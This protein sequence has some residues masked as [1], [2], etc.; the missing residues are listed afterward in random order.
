MR[1]REWPWEEEHTRVVLLWTICVEKEGFILQESFHWESVVDPWEKQSSG[2]GRSRDRVGG[3]IHIGS[4][5]VVCES[6]WWIDPAA[7]G[8]ERDKWLSARLEIVYMFLIDPAAASFYMLRIRNVL[9]LIEWR[10]FPILPV[11]YYP[12]D[13]YKYFFLMGLL[14][15]PYVIRLS[16][17]KS[18]YF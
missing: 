14:D 7:A 15:I 18:Y 12:R 6:L 9:L 4:F 16:F 10:I 2:L 5:F 1:D 17:F 3:R 8:W 11:P 13:I